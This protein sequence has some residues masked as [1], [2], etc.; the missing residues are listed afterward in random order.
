LRQIRVRVS[1]AG[2][3]HVLAELWA[4]QEVKGAS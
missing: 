2:E 3:D 4:A 1:L